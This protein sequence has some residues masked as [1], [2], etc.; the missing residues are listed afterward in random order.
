MKYSAKMPYTR[1]NESNKPNSDTWTIGNSA[2]IAILSV[3]GFFANVVQFTVNPLAISD[4]IKLGCMAFDTANGS[5]KMRLIYLLPTTT[6]K[7]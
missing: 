1:I 3:I 2:P 6:T 5:L 7:N 4:N